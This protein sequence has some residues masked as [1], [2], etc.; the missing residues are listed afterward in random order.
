ML[1][2]LSVLSRR[3]ILLLALAA[4]GAVIVA[5]C[6]AASSDRPTPPPS[7]PNSD[8]TAGDALP[9]PAD[10]AEPTLEV[11]GPS[12][13]DPET[14]AEVPDTDDEASVGTQ[15]EAPPGDEPSSTQDATPEK[16]EPEPGPLTAPRGFDQEFALQILR[17]LTVDIGPR[18]RGTEGE[19]AAATFLA[20]AFTDLGYN[21]ERQPFTL[22]LQGVTALS[23][24]VDGVQ[25]EAGAFTGTVGGDIEARVV[26]V[27][28]LGT[29]SDFADVD[30][31]G[32]VAI[33]ERGILFFQEKVNNASAA[34][35]AAILIY[36]NE[37]GF[38]SGALGDG[39]SIP[40]LSLSR[41]N[42]L[43]I[44]ALSDEATSRA[45]IHIEGGRRLHTSE[46]IIATSGD[47]ACRI[48]VGGHYD[49]VENVDGANDNGS[50]K[51]LVVALAQAFTGVSGADLVCFV[52]FAAE[53]AV[54]GIGGIA[55]SRALVDDLIAEDR[56]ND[57]FAMLNLDVAAAGTPQVIIVG[58]PTFGG[59]T[60]AIANALALDARRGSLGAN[61]GSDH[62][63]FQSVG[64]P[65]IF[66]TVFGA[67]IHEPSDNFEN[68]DAAI[69]DTVG[70][71]A[72]DTLQCLIIGAGGALS[73]PAGCDLGGDL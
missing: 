48:Y 14:E 28:G 1:E 11:D 47:G 39:S 61:T 59:T 4:G 42:G 17:G 10:T 53:E 45:T 9:D 21:V 22:P 27:P 13:A 12:S 30:V 32:A 23:L 20:N 34:G 15:D 70:R 58:D 44:R 52:G 57:V 25:F 55:G 36:N 46:N 41:E 31:Q 65:I 8:Q 67:T 3:M 69:V 35:A 33:V 19:A 49:T 2:H 29:P 72:H 6:S 60:L 62:L 71:L 51:A 43:A 68:V 38:F 54:G 40:A 7:Q 64:I 16:D 18:A 24:A 5:A 66:P 37:P 73:P 56:V 50:G 26:R 63:N